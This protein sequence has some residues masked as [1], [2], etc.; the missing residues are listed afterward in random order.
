MNNPLKT[1]LLTLSENGEGSDIFPDAFL[2]K[3]GCVE[4]EFFKESISPGLFF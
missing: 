2:L 3:N 1:G 4:R